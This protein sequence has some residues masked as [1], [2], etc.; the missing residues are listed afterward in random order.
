[1]TTD[2]SL[3]IV[4][5]SDQI[6][7]EDFLAGPR[8]YTIEG[9][10]ISPGTEQPVNIKLAG[11]N[12]VWRPCKSMSRVLVAGWGPD[13]KA[14]AGRSVTL[15][16]DPRVKWGGMEVGGIRVSHMSHIERE[17]LIQL[18][19]TKGKRA[20]HIVKP[21]VA[22]VRE[23]PKAKQTAEQWASA[24]IADIQ[25]AENEAVLSEIIASGAKAMGK[26]RTDKPDL[27]QRV[28][29]AVEARRGQFAGEGRRDEEYGD[30]HDST[31][32]LPE[33]DG[34]WEE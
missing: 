21:L 24:H 2:M 26:L 4:P 33:A 9:V 6:N 14:Y 10:A 11:E 34:Q 7:A 5:K 12:R 25:S 1:M 16:R 3:V 27:A 17:M 22:E 23:M 30:Q 28:D 20:P 31:D 8:T 32:D 19:A 18:T 15:Y 13:A 29:Q